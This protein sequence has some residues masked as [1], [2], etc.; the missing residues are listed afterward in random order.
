M[1]SEYYYLAASLPTL[2]FGAGAPIAFQDFLRR[3]EEQLSDSDLKIIQKAKLE[4]S[5]APK[6]SC[7][8]LKAFKEFDT[9]LR[10]ELVRMR[11]SKKG[12]DP[13]DYILFI[14]DHST[15]VH[16]PTV[17]DCLVDVPLALRT[18]DIDLLDGRGHGLTS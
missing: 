4:P 2:E 8:I 17:N 15:T 11:A 7:G 18:L 1:S 5:Q 13:L 3:C 16:A 9:Q 10:N 12:K 14:L 6:E